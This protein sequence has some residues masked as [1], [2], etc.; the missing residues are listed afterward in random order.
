MPNLS[1]MVAVL[2]CGGLS[3]C[4]NDNAEH[5]IIRATAT[6]LAAAL[7]IAC[8]AWWVQK[9]TKSVPPLPP[10]PRGLP[11]LGNLPFLQPDLHRYFSKLSQIY[12]PIIK[13]QFGSKICI[14]VSSASVAKEVLQDH[15]AIFANRDPPTVA[16]IGTYGGCDMNPE[17][18]SLPTVSIPK[19]I[20]P[21]TTSDEPNAV[22]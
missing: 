1:S 11:V 9:F 13:L 4:S 10:G 7:A 5:T 12:G 19:A 8:H 17:Q 2:A 20:K 6:L 3:W 15:D 18:S 21:T 14:V 16:I 22:I